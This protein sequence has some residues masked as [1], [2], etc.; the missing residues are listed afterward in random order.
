MSLC[1]S[2]PQKVR[3]SRCDRITGVNAVAATVLLVAIAVA[4]HRNSSSTNRRSSSLV[5]AVNV[6][7]RRKLVR[8]YHSLLFVSFLN[9]LHGAD[10]SD[11]RRESARVANAVYAAFPRP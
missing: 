2:G 1:R 5:V 10:L 11:P 9:F 8:E 7:L 3:H 4:L 6:G